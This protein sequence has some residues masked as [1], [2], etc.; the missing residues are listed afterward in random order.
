MCHVRRNWPGAKVVGTESPGT[1]GRDGTEHLR[2]NESE[3]HVD[4]GQGLQKND[5][6]SK[7]LNGIQNAQPQPQ[8]ARYERARGIPSSPGQIVPD[9][10]DTPPYLDEPWCAQTTGEDRE[11]PTMPL[12]KLA[13]DEKENAPEDAEEGDAEKDNLPC[14]G[15]G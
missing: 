6:K 5:T 4:P 8:T 10:G 2:C 11:E 14:V 3:T 1:D 13:D 15:V 9:A 7:T 12:G